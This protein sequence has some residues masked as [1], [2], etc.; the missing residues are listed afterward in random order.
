MVTFTVGFSTLE[1]DENKDFLRVYGC[2]QPTCAATQ[3]MLDSGNF[4]GSH[5]GL[6]VTVEARALLLR[7]SSG[8][9]K[10]SAGGFVLHWATSFRR[11]VRHYSS[12]VDLP[13]EAY[14]IRTSGRRSVSKDCAHFVEV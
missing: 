12:S 13:N 6:N 10:I 1:N 14:A 3:H 2:D 5:E 11:R 9:N 8:Q 7:L 4:F